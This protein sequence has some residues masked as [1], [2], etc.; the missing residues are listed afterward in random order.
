MVTLYIKQ[1]TIV[2]KMTELVN[3]IAPEFRFAK[4]QDDEYHVFSLYVK[5]P[6]EVDN[7]MAVK[8]KHN[9]LID[10]QTFADLKNTYIEWIFDEENVIVACKKR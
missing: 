7:W 6:D 2:N 10:P 4:R 8:T 3:F 5:N 9:V 1:C